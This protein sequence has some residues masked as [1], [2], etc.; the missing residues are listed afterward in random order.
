[1]VEIYPGENLGVHENKSGG[2]LAQ[3]P[4]GRFG[5]VLSWRKFPA[6]RYKNRMPTLSSDNTDGIHPCPKRL[7]QKEPQAPQQWNKRYA[8]DLYYKYILLLCVNLGGT[9]TLCINTQTLNSS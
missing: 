6:I 8:R 5:E 4:C 1:M 9:S 3:D 2:N 7:L